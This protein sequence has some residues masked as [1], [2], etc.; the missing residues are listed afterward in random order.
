MTKESL[1]LNPN[2]RV[3]D[4]YIDN[5]MKQIHFMNLEINLLK[6]KQE[7]N[8]DVMGIR[9]LMQKDKNAY[10]DHIIEANTKFMELLKNMA[11]EKIALD[12]RMLRTQEKEQKLVILRDLHKKRF[13]E[14]A[15]RYRDSDDKLRNQIKELRDKLKADRD[16]RAEMQ[17][18]LDRLGKQ[19]G[20]AKTKNEELTKY[21]SEKNLF[22][23]IQK[24]LD[25]D[26]DKIILEQIAFKTQ[27]VEGTMATRDEKLK[28]LNDDARL[29][30]LKTVNHQ[31]QDELNKKQLE[32]SET[33]YKVMEI[34]ARQQLAVKVKE[35]DAQD[36]KNLYDEYE[37]LKEK[38]DEEI[39]KNNDRVEKKLRESTF[40]ELGK[41]DILVRKAQEELNTLKVQ[42][43]K[44][45]KEYKNFKL[46]ELRKTTYLD[47]LK[48]END[49]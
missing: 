1:G 20:E 8:K 11:N 14:G 25:D 16:F 27:L 24:D 9:A 41:R 5:L 46:D 17:A 36:R 32:A 7:E 35:K 33:E 31:L 23:K 47:K 34:E 40:E 18:Q 37:I 26:E 43:D 45:H 21:V 38:L 13:E 12:D 15:K 10:V 22:D 48:K 19:T 49:K 2:I 30:D 4:E 44:I 28:A 3:E 29:K 42:Y 39:K 6:Q